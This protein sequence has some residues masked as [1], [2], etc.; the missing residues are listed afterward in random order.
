MAGGVWWWMN[1]LVVLTVLGVKARH[2]VFSGLAAMV[3]DVF[4]AYAP[5]FIL[6]LGDLGD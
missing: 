2:Y 1:D 3:D 4:L 5:L 6:V